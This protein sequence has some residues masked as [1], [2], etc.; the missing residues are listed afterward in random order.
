MLLGLCASVY[1][2]KFIQLG[3]ISQKLKVEFNFY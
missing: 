1:Y 2:S 3:Y